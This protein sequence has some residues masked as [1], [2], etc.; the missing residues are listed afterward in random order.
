[1]SSIEEKRSC[2]TITIQQLAEND[3]NT[4]VKPIL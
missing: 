2:K 1:M 4:K 3:F